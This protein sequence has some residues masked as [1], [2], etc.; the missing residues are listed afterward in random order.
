MHLETAREAVHAGKFTPS[1]TPHEAAQAGK[2]TPAEKSKESKKR[3]NRDH[4]RSLETNNK[5]AKSLD[6]R[7]PRPPSSKYTNFTKLTGSHEED[8]LATEQTGVFK[9][10]DPLLGDRSKRNQSKYYRYHKDVGHMTEECVMLKDEIEKLIGNG[11]LY[12]R[13][14]RDR[15]H[16]DQNEAK[17]LCE[18]RTIFGW[19]H[20][21]GET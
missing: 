5:K 3:K 8:L 14:K 11:Y 13:D 12:V 18:I 6:Q 1:E 20:F 10:P 19:P 16:S 21:V 2:P 7:V 9:R 4:Q 15:S 17:P